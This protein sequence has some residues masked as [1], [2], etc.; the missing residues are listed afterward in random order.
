M[1]GQPRSHQ[2]EGLVSFPQP[3]GK[4]G[5]ELSKCWSYLSP[6]RLTEEAA[7]QSAAAY[8]GPRLVSTR[9]ALRPSPLP[10]APLPGLP[11]PTP[12]ASAAANPPPA[13]TAAAPPSAGGGG[14]GVRAEGGLPA[15]QPP[16]GG[17]RPPLRVPRWAQTPQQPATHRSGTPAPPPNG[18]RR[19]RTSSAPSAAPG[20][21]HPP[22]RTKSPE[23]P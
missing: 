8:T 9:P 13:G 10:G 14:S 3:A 22:R 7:G 17:P 19:A 18:A 20:N 23:G 5:M 15:C 12:G 11:P 1:K 4:V 21:G 2:I 6:T 16:C